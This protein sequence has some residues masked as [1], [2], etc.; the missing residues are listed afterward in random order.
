M[1]GIFEFWWNNFF[2]GMKLNFKFE[3]WGKFYKGFP[4]KNFFPGESF[5][6][7]THI[8]FSGDSFVKFPVGGSSSI[9]KGIPYSN[10]REIILK[11]ISLLKKFY[12]NYL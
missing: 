4:C 3:S 7:W 6:K 10:S 1:C 12:G 11:M 2:M 9:Y 5:V 8:K